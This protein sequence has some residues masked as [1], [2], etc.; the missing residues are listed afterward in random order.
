MQR[1]NVSNW[2]EINT[3]KSCNSRIRMESRH[4]FPLPFFLFFFFEDK[5]RS[6]N[7]STCTWQTTLNNSVLFSMLSPKNPSTATAL[8]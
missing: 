3:A 1:F 6:I 8:P 2:N 4:I 5:Q 7:P